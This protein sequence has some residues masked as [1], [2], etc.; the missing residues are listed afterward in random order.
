[1]SDMSCS[2]VSVSSFPPVSLLGPSE[3]SSPTAWLIW[4]DSVDTK[5]GGGS[6]LLYVLL[7]SKQLFT[8][9]Y[10][11]QEGIM[12]TVIGGLAKFWIP[13]WPETAKFLT[14]EERTLLIR[15]LRVDTGDARM[16][17]LDRKSAKRIFL[18]WKIWCGTL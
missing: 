4:V 2:G 14:D 17:R 10:A 12:T 13:D 1:M 9:S 16:D 7:D 8:P 18:D 15:K 11:S 5:A 6:S 3:V